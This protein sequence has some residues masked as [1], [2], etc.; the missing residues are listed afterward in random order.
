MI[1]KRW[2]RSP[3]GRRVLAL[4]WIATV[5]CVTALSAA[6][7]WR[8]Q[9]PAT[10]IEG[11][12][13]AAQIGALA[14]RGRAEREEGRLEDA[15]R[16]LREAQSLAEGAGDFASVVVLESDVGLCHAA[17]G[18]LDD[19][20]AAYRRILELLEKVDDPAFVAAVSVHARADSALTL[21][22]L[23]RAHEAVETAR[24]GAR[25]ADGTDDNGARA[26]IWSALG[27][28]LMAT[29]KIAEAPAWFQRAAQAVESLDLAT[30]PR[31]EIVCNLAECLGELGDKPA[32]RALVDEV[33]ATIEAVPAVIPTVASQAY[34]VRGVLEF[35]DDWARSEADLRRAQSFLA[36]AGKSDGD[37]ARLLTDLY[38]AHAV[39]NAGRPS[40]SAA[41]ERA[42]LTKV[43]E[44]LGADHPYACLALKFLAGSLWDMGDKSGERSRYDEARALYEEAAALARRTRAPDAFTVFASLGT[45]L[46]DRF[47]DPRA[48]EPW[49]RAAVDEVEASSS[50]ALAVDEATRSALFRQQRINKRHDPYEALLRCLVRL[51]RPE[52]A[53]LILELSRARGLNDLLERSRF[54]AV[55]EARR[56]A[57]ESGDAEPAQRLSLL[58]REMDAAL[59]AVAN[60]ARSNGSDAERNA[61]VALAHARVGDLSAERARLTQSVT[62]AATPADIP[63]IRRALT[64][65]EALVAYFLGRTESF[66]CLA[67]G[68]A[69]K[70]TWFPLRDAD[71]KPLSLERIATDVGAALDV[72]SGPG[73]SAARGVAVGSA[74]DTTQDASAPQRLFQRIVPAALWERI[75][76]RSLVYLLPHGA[77]YRLPFEALVV[78]SGVDGSGTRYWLDEGPPIAYQESGSALVWSLRRREAQKRQPAAMDAVIVAD[79]E[80]AAA[81]DSVPVATSGLAIARVRRGGPASRA[82][83]IA[84]DVVTAYD[85]T[86]ITKSTELERKWREGSGASAREREIVVMRGG[87]ARR[88]GIEGGDPELE[89]GEVVRDR[90]PP[91]WSEAARPKLERLTGTA[92]EAEAVRVALSASADRGGRRVRVFTGA[93]ATE[94]LLFAW[95]PRAAIVHI[96]AHQ[97]ADPFGRWEAGRLALTS[98]AVLTSEDDGYVDLDDLLVHWRRR[99]DRCELVV[100]ASCRSRLGRLETDEGLYALPIGFRFAGCPS[101]VASLWPVDDS[102]TATLMTTFYGADRAQNA[103]AEPPRLAAFT[104]ARRALRKQ[105]PEPFAWAPFV[106]TGAPR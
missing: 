89:L 54:D 10:K 40:E 92:R 24:D 9:D 106:W 37:P 78:R 69:G 83:L 105:R 19:Q 90:E 5:A 35:R 42:T 34:S 77:L 28:S 58:P 3:G 71:L 39:R 61:A 4:P 55:D 85:G 97:I 74:L 60:A 101:V 6:P 27:S 46:L 50:S 79:P 14:N 96:A 94:T 56:R 36:A 65:D 102:A 87:V 25:R 16:T 29:G 7:T 18:R 91:A 72:L 51:D 103:T 13:P 99:L 12:G 95:A 52:D 73:G 75:K 81:L 57:D 1:H 93:D 64:G 59:V 47:D 44:R 45:L 53:L 84:G 33:I 86:P 31:S 11:L 98:P 67:E 38:I 23:G 88:L 62:E 41:L 15:V 82:G 49:L 20:L 100:L 43:R 104:A 8:E 21:I 68:L 48:A 22:R 2:A 30:P 76:D 17:A 66:V 70:V 32:A 63:T 26:A 80:Y